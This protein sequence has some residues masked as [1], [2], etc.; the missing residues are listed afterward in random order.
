MRAISSVQNPCDRL[1][2]TAA[3]TQM[4]MPTPDPR[5]QAFNF[6]NTDDYPKTLDKSGPVD[7]G[8]YS[9]LLENSIQDRGADLYCSLIFH[10]LAEGR[11]WF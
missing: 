11:T 2:A 7:F 1:V 5:R 9:W 6:Q 3:S 4:P 8:G 10:S